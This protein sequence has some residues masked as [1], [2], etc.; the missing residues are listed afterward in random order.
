MQKAETTGSDPLKYP[1]RFG[2]AAVEFGYITPEQ[3]REA[4]IEQLDIN[5]GTGVHRLIGEI[6]HTR[7]WMTLEQIEATLE[8][9]E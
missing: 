5:L 4:M 2:M 6:L 3:L 1:S 8:K 7:G 9:M